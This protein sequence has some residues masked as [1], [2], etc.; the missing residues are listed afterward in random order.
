MYKR[1][2]LVAQALDA[3]Y[4]QIQYLAKATIFHL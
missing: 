4:Y 3:R 2:F 1:K